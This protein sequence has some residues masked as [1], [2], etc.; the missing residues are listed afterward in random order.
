MSTPTSYHEV[1]QWSDAQ[2]RDFLIA[3]RW[4]EGVICP[5]CGAPEPYTLTRKSKTKNHVTKLFKCR[6]CRKQ[7]T[8]TTGTIFEDSHVSLSKWFS[9]IYLMCASKKGVSAHQIHRMLGVAYRTAWFMCHRIREAMR[10]GNWQLSGTIEADETFVGG[11]KSRRGHPVANWERKRID[12]EARGLPVQSWMRGQRHPREDKTIV[13]GIMERGGRVRSQVVP[14]VQ[15]EHL[16]PVMI[17]DIDVKRSRLITDGHNVYKGMRDVMPHD[18]VN[19]DIEYV[20]YDSPDVHTQGIENYWSLVKR[21]ILGTWHH[22]GVSYLDQYLRE[23][24]YRFNRRQISDAAR[25]DALFGQVSGKR[26][27]WYCRTPQPENPHA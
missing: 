14:A 7:F 11:K 4:P 17:R 19:H 20:R 2:C 25:F 23:F 27:T 21:G 16:R 12:A 8:A 22:V 26:L 9:A 6:A 13:F 24:D 5:K 15:I 10:E 18:S 3:Q 1:M